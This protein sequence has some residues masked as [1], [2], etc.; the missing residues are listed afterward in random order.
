[1]YNTHVEKCV[2]KLHTFLNSHCSRKTDDPR[3]LPPQTCYIPAKEGQTWS[4]VID[5]TEYNNKINITNLNPTAS[6]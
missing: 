5:L 4:M 1:M 2:S 6:K 3:V